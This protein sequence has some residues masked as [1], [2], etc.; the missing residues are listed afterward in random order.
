MQRTGTASSN[1]S[2]KRTYSVGEVFESAVGAVHGLS[3]FVRLVS[4]GAC[5]LAG[6][7]TGVLRGPGAPDGHHGPGVRGERH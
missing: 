3:D 5:A 4:K 6:Q 7:S 1:A 2:L